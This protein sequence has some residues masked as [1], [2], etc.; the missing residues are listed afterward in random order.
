M[1]NTGQ[2]FLRVIVT[3]ASGMVGE[4]VL[5]E[6][7]QHNIISEVLVIGRTP[8]G[9]THPKLKE[10]IHKN[11]FDVTAIESQLAGY[12]AC[13]F[14]LGVTSLGKK[15]AEY[16]D[17][18]YTLT[19]TFAETLVKHNANMVFCYVSGA[20]TDS[21]EKGR[22]MWA[23]VKGKTEN[24]LLKMPFKKA[25]MF[26]PGFLH[27]T[28]G[29]QHAHKFYAYIKWMYPILKAVV[30]NTVSTLAQLGQAMINV[31]LQ[32]YEKPILEVSD[33]NKL[34]GKV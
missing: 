21:T 7:L 2:K 8:C 31:L 19:I 27:P 30:P 22:V 20:H 14:C 17:L 32:G 33:I 29:L 13:L 11:F 12:D 5:H 3:G 10:V 26:R 23:R 1:N 15:E 34:A 18:T 24:E 6:C 25:Y 9:I 4:G 16:F 28:K